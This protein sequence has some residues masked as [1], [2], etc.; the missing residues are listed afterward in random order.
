MGKKAAKSTRKF[1]ASGQL[2]KTIQARHKHQQI[3]KRNQNRR[4]NKDGKHKQ[5]VEKD[6]SDGTEEEEEEEEVE[7]KEK[8]RKREK[9]S[10][11]MTV[12]DFLK[13]DF[14]EESDDDAEI[15]DGDEED[16]GLDADIEEDESVADDDS[17]ASI[18]DLDDEGEAHMLELAKLAE[19]DPEFYKY[20]QENDRELLEFDATKDEEMD[21]SDEEDEEG[22][23]EEQEA[24]L[25]KLTLQIIKKWQKALLE[26][27]SLRALRKLLIAF[28]LAAHLNEEDQKLAWSIDNS[29]VYNKLVTTSLRY[30]PIVLEHHVPYKKLPNGKFRPP[31]QTTKFKTLQKLILSYFLNIIHMVS[32][33]TDNEL[34]CLALSESSKLIPYITSGR[35]AVKLYL[36]SC[37]ELWSSAEDDVRLA[38]FVAIRKLASS[39][40]E[41]I[42][43][44]VLRGTYLTLFRSSKSTTVYTL[45]SINLMKNS[46]SDVFCIDHA[47]SYQQAFGF[48]R[49][50]AIHLRNG[51]KLRTKEAYKEVYNWQFA[52]SIDFWCIVLAKACD[53]RL[54]AQNG[55]K[56]SELKALV[57]PLV[58]VSLGSIRLVPNSRSHPFHLHIIRSLLHLIKHTHIYI[59]ISP[60]LVP[61]ITSSLTPSSRPKSSTLRPLDLEV[62]IRVPQQYIKTRIYLEGMMEE[63]SYLLAEWLSC[64]VVQAS[65]A[66][67]EIV[68][69]IVVSLRRTLKEAK[70]GHG[71]I[72]DQGIV[73]TLLERIEE[74][75][76]WVE[77]RRKNVSFAPGNMNNVS[78]W[79][80][81]LKSKVADAPLSKYLKVQRKVREK[82]QKLV[83]KAR[84]GE[85]TTLEE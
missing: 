39:S 43:D 17:F 46:A 82:R 28:R 16:E 33:M 56:E 5:R 18:D 71:S 58:Q 84:K 31:T 36:K 70:S 29:A 12:D 15:E 22:F 23:D 59:P 85:K 19:K 25:P 74:S 30:T 14:M 32:Q 77:E 68:I 7:V 60:Y 10:K 44:H 53:V 49:Q 75:A 8:P 3:R 80:Q 76:Q 78:E 64:E 51:M 66:F 61:I 73:K 79:E 9:G 37:L 34:L 41:S 81:D 47:M 50:L 24:V 38:A 20:L 45:P 40:E 54:L 4:G 63:S 72:K 55:G 52:H 65:I 1:A 35:K 21:V 42:L 27:Q 26:Q 13:G 2:K 57:Y 48:I 69:P 83:E 67:P 11:P 6:D 62:H